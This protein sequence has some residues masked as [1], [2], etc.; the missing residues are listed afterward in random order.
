MTPRHFAW[1]AWHLVTSTCVSRGR[2]G[3]ISHPPSFC[4]AGVALMALG[5][6]LGPHDAYVTSTLLSETI[7]HTSL[8]HTICHIPSLSQTICLNV[9]SRTIFHTIFVNNS[10]THI[11]VTHHP[12]A[13]CLTHIIIFHTHFVTY[14]LSHTTLSHTV[15]HILSFTSRFGSSKSE[16]S[17][18][19]FG[20]ARLLPLLRLTDRS[21]GPVR[22]TSSASFRLSSTTLMR[23]ADSLRAWTRFN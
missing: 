14:H 18:K 19:P 8:S 5:G 10:L 7:S 16:W 12:S 23:A 13:S 1:Q 3:T 4:V 17:R 22:S 2:C 9:L 20:S 21:L 15:F 6:A 11:F